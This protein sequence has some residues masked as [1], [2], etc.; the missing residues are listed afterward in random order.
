MMKAVD[1]LGDKVTP[2]DLRA[3]G[4]MSL[5]SSLVELQKLKKTVDKEDLE[6]M[7][8]LA[9]VIMKYSES[10]R[11]ELARCDWSLRM[12][13]S[14]KSMLSDPDYIRR[15]TVLEDYVRDA[16]KDLPFLER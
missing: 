6:R 14:F 10:H 13:A 7:S 3:L 12:L 2:D 1:K 16:R 4:I 15:V 9:R 8:V 5:Q 11:G